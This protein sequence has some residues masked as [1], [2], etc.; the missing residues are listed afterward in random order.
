[1][2]VM[3]GRLNRR[4]SLTLLLWYFHVMMVEAAGEGRGRLRT[5]QVMTTLLQ[6]QFNTHGRIER[7][8]KGRVS[9]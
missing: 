5:R 6:S 4:M 9:R 3:R 2:R 1:M 8:G 7:C